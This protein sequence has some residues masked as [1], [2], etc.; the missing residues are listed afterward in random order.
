MA[1]AVTQVVSDG[2]P[3][4][5]HDQ[6]DGAFTST[7]QCQTTSTKRSSSGAGLPSPR[8]LESFQAVLGLTGFPRSVD[9]S[10][11][12]EIPA[13]RASSVR[14]HPR[15]AQAAFS[16]VGTTITTRPPAPSRNGV[17]Q[18]CW[19]PSF[20]LD[21]W[22]EPRRKDPACTAA[23]WVGEPDAPP[24]P[25]APFPRRQGDAMSGAPGDKRPVTD[26]AENG[27]ESGSGSA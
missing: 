15:R 25:P 17:W 3:E 7:V 19:D 20:P 1:I 2:K 11:G 4:D 23:P 22:S 5:R 6:L 21:G 26:E 18:S 14:L 16:C 27:R 8:A 9:F 10:V 13:R 24:V 12:Y